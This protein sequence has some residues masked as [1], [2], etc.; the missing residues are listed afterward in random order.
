MIA[1]FTGRA[2]LNLG[3]TILLILVVILAVWLA[4]S[5]LGFVI[6]G[7][8]WLAIIGLVLFL[9]TS[10]FGFMQNKSKR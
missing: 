10:L 8:F 7:L 4:V 9:A 2:L 5:V 3:L 6:K 1:T